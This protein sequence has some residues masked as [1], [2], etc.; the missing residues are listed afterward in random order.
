MAQTL[1][2]ALSEARINFSMRKLHPRPLA[3]RGQG[4]GGDAQRAIL[5]SV[6]RALC[7][8]DQERA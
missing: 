5:R 6:R 4:V 8:L 3:G 1:E 2:A 7:K